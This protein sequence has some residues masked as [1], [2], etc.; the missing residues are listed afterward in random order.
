MDSFTRLAAQQP[1]I[2]F[3]LLSAL[4]A[5]AVGALVLARR[6]GNGS[7]RAL[8]W[9]WVALMGGATLTSAFIRDHGM[10]NLGGVTPVH[11]L[12]LTVGV[13]LPRAVLA[14]R[15][16]DIAAHR[17]SMRGIYIGG[18]IVAGLFTLL[19]ARF[20]G[21]LLWSALGVAA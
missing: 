2:F 21:R 7:H 11:L 14:A 20:L 1:L 19:P 9:I 5:L 10:P 12:T 17:R 18:C 3:H 8:G 4:A 15:R 13:L 16:G 6:K